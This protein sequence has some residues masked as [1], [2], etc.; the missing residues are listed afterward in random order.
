[1]NDIELVKRICEGDENSFRLLVE[2]YQDNVFRTCYGF[3]KNVEDAEDLTQE[4]F[5]KVFHKIKDFRGDSE[6]STWLFRISVN[7]SINVLRQ[8]KRRL[9]FENIENIIFNSGKRSQNALTDIPADEQIEKNQREKAI[10]TAIDELP[11][12]QKSAFILHKY[13]DLSQIE[14]AEIMKT[15]VSAVES[16]IHRAKQNLQQKLISVYKGNI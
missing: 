11:A 3:I 13:D 8:N 15:S 14:I 1:M 6:F 10:N 9:L 16:L 5:I 4:I 7:M 12:N 2:K